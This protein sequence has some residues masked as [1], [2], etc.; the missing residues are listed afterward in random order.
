MLHYYIGTEH[1]LLGVLAQPE[2]I[3]YKAIESYNIRREEIRYHLKQNIE[4]FSGDTASAL[5]IDPINI[6]AHNTYHQIHSTPI[7]K[8]FALFRSKKAK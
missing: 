8:L 1:L 2:S 6:E 4:E 5:R 7:S 3:A